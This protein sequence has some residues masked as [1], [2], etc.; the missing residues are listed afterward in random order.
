MNFDDK[1]IEKPTRCENWSAAIIVYGN[2]CRL[3]S[4]IYEG[5]PKNNE[6]C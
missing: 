1:C 2:H 4:S 5:H 6:S 3:S